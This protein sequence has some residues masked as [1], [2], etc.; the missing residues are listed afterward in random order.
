VLVDDAGVARP[1]HVIASLHASWMDRVPVV[2]EMATDPEA[3]RRPARD[4][5]PVHGLDP[6]LVIA[7]DRL[8]FLVWANNYD[9]RAG[10]PVWWWSRKAAAAGATAGPEGGPDVSLP[11][12]SP[13]WVDGGPRWSVPELGEPIVHRESV[14]AGSLTTVTRG[15]DPD[16]DLAPDQLAAVAHDGGPVRVIAPA[17]SGKTRVLTERLRYLLAERG[18]ERAGVLGVAYNKEAQRELESRLAG[19]EPR[20]RTLNAL[21]YHL[22][23][24]HRGVRPPVLD[25]LEVRAIVDEVFPV[26]RRMANTD[27]V[28]PYLDALTQVRLGLV[29]PETIEADRDDVPGLAEGFAAYRERLAASG[30]IDFDEQVYGSIEAL[31]CDGGFR[32]RMQPAHRHLL[33]DEFQDLTPA[34]VLLLRLLAMPMLDVFGVG[35]DDQTIYDHAGADPR[36]L[37]DFGGFFPRAESVAL[38]VNYRCPTA[39]VQAASRLLAYNEIR[40][41]KAIRPGPAADAEPTALRIITSAPDAGASALVEIVGEWLAEPGVE[42]H[43]VAVLARVNSLLL[44]PQVA[45]QAAG[46]PVHSVLRADVLER[47]GI[48]AAL[49]WLRVALEPE[50]LMPA[51]LETIRRRPSRGFPNWISKW[52]SRCRSLNALRG[53]SAKIDDERVA[54]KVEEL[55][56]AIEL[57][58]RAAAEGADTRTL[59]ELVRDGIGLGGAMDL[60]DGS[61]GNQGAASHLDDLEALLGVADLHPDPAAF[62]PW[63]R[64]SLARPATDGGVTLSTV[65]RVK[66]REWNRVAVFG[67]TAGLLPHRL[68]ED[69]EAERRVLHVAITRARHRCAVL[70]DAERVSPFLD[71]LRGSAEEAF[72]QPS[73]E[74]AVK[75]AGRRAAAKAAPSVP[76]S[77]EGEEAERALRAW[78]AE[79]CARDGVPAYV[80]LANKHIAGIAAAMPADAAELRACDGIGPAKLERY[81]DEILAVLDSVRGAEAK[82]VG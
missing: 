44:A 8:H 79:R 11:G 56:D 43:E 16:A 33:V 80:V 19:L 28:G 74:V 24:E 71:E 21:G 65:H 57:A 69:A 73:H 18:Y 54:G 37:V 4:S 22:L 55:A 82:P 5:S 20:T 12:G 41:E 66:G 39:T 61:K 13:A 46:V 42:P 1:E 6:A 35:D 15:G 2:V 72:R 53:I 49:A 63:L 7:S 45:L 81:G 70:G 31:M 58:G 62:E 67:V 77:A 47:T 30:S 59:L 50:A 17:G 40:V 52:F 23:A 38:E 25:E 78:R 14:E 34:H 29:D 27:P 48:A 3:F 60:L 36:F 68:A 9:A 51:D 10:E 64:E 26:P 32:R 76:L 75:A